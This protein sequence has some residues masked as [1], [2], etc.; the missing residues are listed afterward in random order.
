MSSHKNVILYVFYQDGREQHI[1]GSYIQEV[2][3]RAAHRAGNRHRSTKQ[4][5]AI[6]EKCREVMRPAGTFLLHWCLPH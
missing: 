6:E 2:F 4:S 1:Y 5:T 3:H